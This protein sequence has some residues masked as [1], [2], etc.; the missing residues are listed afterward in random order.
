MRR[1]L[2]VLSLL[3]LGLVA[4]RQAATD[5][6]TVDTLSAERREASEKLLKQNCQ[7][8]HAP[9]VGADTRLAPPFFAIRKHYLKEYPEKG[10]FIKAIMAFVDKPSEEKVLMKGAREKFGLMPP[11]N[12]DVK[13]LNDLAIYLYDEEQPSPHQPTSDV[14]IQSPESEVKRLALSTKKVLGQNLMQALSKGGKDYALSFCNLN[15]IHLT[16]S[17]SQ[18]LNSAIKRVSDRP[19]NPENRATEAEANLIQ[20]YQKMLRNGEALNPRIVKTDQGLKGYHAI[21]TMSMCLQCHGKKGTELDLSFYQEINK[22]YPEDEAHG[23]GLDEIR[24]L[25]IIAL[26]SL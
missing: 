12:L 15:A 6:I 16:D 21:T 26:D 22:L 3:I 17:M 10:D 4:C 14:E 24:G 7:N 23:Y 18:H 13:E 2:T 11:I 1:I 25:W 8:C 5:T 9:F 20:E 19:R